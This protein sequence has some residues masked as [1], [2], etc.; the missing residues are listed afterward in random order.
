MQEQKFSVKL[1]E[2]LYL[3]LEKEVRGLNFTTVD[4]FVE[5]LLSQTYKVVAEDNISKEE[6]EEIKKRLEILGYL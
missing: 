4:E 2:K 6:E 1:S 5:H 3:L